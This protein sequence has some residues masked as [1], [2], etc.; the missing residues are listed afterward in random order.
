MSG[1]VSILDN[2]E[3]RLEV[4]FG[5]IDT[6]AAGTIITAEFKAFLAGGD[7]SAKIVH[8]QARHWIRSPDEDGY[9]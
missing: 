2:A 7:M 1:G 5:N 9:A 6:D 4:V 3:P 8:A